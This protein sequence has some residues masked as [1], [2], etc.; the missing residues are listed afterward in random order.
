MTTKVNPALGKLDETATEPESSESASETDEPTPRVTPQHQETDSMDTDAE[1][2]DGSTTPTPINF[3]NIPVDNTAEEEEE[4]EFDFDIP[5]IVQTTQQLSEQEVAKILKQALD[6]DEEDYGMLLEYQISK[7]QPWRSFD[8]MPHPPNSLI[9]PPCA[10]KPKQ[11]Q[12]GDQ[13]FGCFKSN[14]STCNIQFRH[15]VTRAIMTGIIDEIWQIPLERH[16]QTFIMVQ[17]HKLLSDTLL[18]KTPFPTFPL[19][20]VTAVHAQHSNEFCIIEPE[21]IIAHLTGYQRP[22]GTFGINKA[23]LVICHA[24]N[25]GRR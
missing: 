18:Q 14:R 8:Q 21:H 3:L 7:G 24:A 15:P 10:L 13:D 6:L 9:L 25:R 1:S 12:L 22:K 20:E 17:K 5:G 16:L 2:V 4:D 19:F 23:I 11:I